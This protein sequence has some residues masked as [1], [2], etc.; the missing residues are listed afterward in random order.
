MQKSYRI[1]RFW[2]AVIVIVM[3][4]IGVSATPIGLQAQGEGSGVA[5]AH[6]VLQANAADPALNRICVGETVPLRVRVELDSMQWYGSGTAGGVRVTGGQFSATIGDPSIVQVD[7]ASLPSGT[8]VD[9]PFQTDVEIVGRAPGTTSVT[10]NARLQGDIPI[11]QDADEEVG[12]PFS[13]TD[14][15]S[16]VTV[17]VRVMYCAYE[18]TINSIWETSM[19]GAFTILIANARSLRLR[20]SST[21]ENAFEFRSAPMTAPYLQ[22][23]WANN[24]IIGCRVS[25]GRFDSQAPD[26]TAV[27]GESSISV[28]ITYLRAV[29]GGPMSHYYM[30]L[31]LPHFTAEPCSAR[32]DGHCFTMPPN[33]PVDWFEPQRLDLTFDLDG[34]TRNP[35]HRIRHS[36][37]DADGWGTVTL[38]PVPVQP[39]R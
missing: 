2:Q 28:A 18:I 35:T 10:I 30:N 16:P 34:G 21:Q 29:P 15:A 33:R 13:F 32:P 5:S 37:G 12:L 8:L 26:V 39:A 25:S 17:N 11:F 38:T 6:H 1:T 7:Q 22:W 20:P 9:V 27:V 19:H 36:W 4:G 3:V 23:T 14:E 24:R 31:C